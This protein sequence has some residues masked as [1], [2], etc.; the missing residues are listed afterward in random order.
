MA[1]TAD[2]LATPLSSAHSPSGTLSGLT[3]KLTSE[4]PLSETDTEDQ[5]EA[6]SPCVERAARRIQRKG[7]RSAS[8]RNFTI[9]EYLRVH[10]SL[11]SPALGPAVLSN[12]ADEER[13]T[14]EQVSTIENTEPHAD[15]DEDSEAGDRET[16]QDRSNVL[17][18]TTGLASATEEPRIT[19]TPSFNPKTHTI[20][21]IVQ[22][23]REFM[24]SNYTD[25]PGHAY[26]LY[27]RSGESPFL[28]IG[29]SVRVSV[30]KG[31]HQRECQLET[32]DT[33]QRP[34]T[35]IPRP[36]RLERIVQAELRN[37]AYDPSCICG[38]KHQEYFWVSKEA[39][40]ELL[41]FWAGWLK[42]HEPY[43]EEENLKAFW[44][45]RLD[46]FQENTHVYFRCNSEQ[47]ANQDEDAPACQACL[48]A[49]WNK[50]A[51]PTASE[52]FEKRK[53]DP[54]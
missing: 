42:V 34:V 50:W 20:H 49:G 21:E 52:E 31:R 2:L 48:R 12:T 51:E 4:T 46:Q 8:R 41:D 47:C 7:P 19:E 25:N 15:D 36:M 18:E 28:K 29:K 24:E 17:P 10:N 44:V 13:E 9:Q 26:L 14:E 53:R 45:D 33:K 37:L 3:A 32:W 16:T 23:M 40:L 39:G 1:L 27:D 54:G 11:E 35:S 22:R 5:F 30:R 38:V 43:D 6:P